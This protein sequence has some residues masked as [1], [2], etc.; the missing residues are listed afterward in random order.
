MKGKQN[1]G[2]VARTLHRIHLYDS[3]IRVLF[4]I[5]QVIL[6]GSPYVALLIHSDWLF[7]LPFTVDHLARQVN[8]TYGKQSGIDVVVDGTLVKHDVI[9]VVGTDMMDRLPLPNQWRN[10]VVYPAELFCGQ[11][12]ALPALTTDSFIFFLCF[13]AIINLLFQSAGTD[14]FTGIAGIRRF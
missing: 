4:L 7:P 6:V 8:I 13:L 10:D 3:D 2:A 5:L 14:L 11:V 1:L 9:C 12:D